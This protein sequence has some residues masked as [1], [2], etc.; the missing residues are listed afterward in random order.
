MDDARVYNRALSQA[1]VAY[2]A[3]TSPGDGQL[4]IPVTS[5]AELYS[6]EAAGSRK[7]NFKDFAVLSTTW[8]E[9]KLWP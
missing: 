6:G 4:Y 5:P 2:L 3:D 8:L 7:V 9:E 1:E